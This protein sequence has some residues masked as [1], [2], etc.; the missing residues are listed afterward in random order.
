MEIVH[1]LFY[2]NENYLEKS[3]TEEWNVYYVLRT[4]Y[5]ACG[6]WLELQKLLVT[7]QNRYALFPNFFFVFVRYFVTHRRKPEYLLGL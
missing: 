7:R 3:C 5:M 1:K 4:I 2:M 6:F